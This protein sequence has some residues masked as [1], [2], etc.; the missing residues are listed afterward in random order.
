MAVIWRRRA[1][2]QRSLIAPPSQYRV[3]VSIYFF[4]FDFAHIIFLILRCSMPR[5]ASHNVPGIFAFINQ[6]ANIRLNYD[7]FVVRH[8]SSQPSPR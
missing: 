6:S 3:S 5:C 2:L 8:S 1:S 7:Y 4:A